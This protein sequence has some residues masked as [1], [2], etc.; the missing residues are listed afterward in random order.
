[1]IIESL[2]VFLLGTAAIFV[3][4]GVIFVALHVLQYLTREKKKP[5]AEE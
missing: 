4:M 5:E 3:V 1:M 2:Q